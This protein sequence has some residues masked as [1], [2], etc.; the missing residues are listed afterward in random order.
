MR[1]MRQCRRRGRPSRRWIV[2]VS[3]LLSML[4]LASCGGAAGASGGS[5]GGGA[6]GGEGAGGDDGGSTSGPAFTVPDSVTLSAFHS[7]AAQTGN[8][9]AIDTS[10]VAEGYV[11]EIGRAHV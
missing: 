10:A 7:D 8:G 6:P 5:G 2:L 9:C 4:L 3:A 11:G 1:V